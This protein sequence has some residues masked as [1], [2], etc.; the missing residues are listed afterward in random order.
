MNK[1]NQP[2]FTQIRTALFNRTPTRV[3]LFE[4]GISP[5]VMEKFLA[6]KINSLKDEVEFYYKAG[7]DYIKLSP[8][9]YH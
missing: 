3:P 8:N 2:D 5:V 7:Y 9:I 6:K 4:L 1:F